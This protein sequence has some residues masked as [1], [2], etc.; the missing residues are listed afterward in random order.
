MA[1]KNQN[2]PES[3]NAKNKSVSP[4][5]TTTI[6]SNTVPPDSVSPRGGSITPPSRENHE[7]LSKEK[8]VARQ[9]FADN[10]N[11][12]SGDGGS[13]S[14][15]GGI[16]VGGGGSGGGNSG[17][18]VSSSPNRGLKRPRESRDS[19][20]LQCYLCNRVFQ[21]KQGLSGHMKSHK[22]RAW[23]GINPPPLFS[24]NEFMDLFVEINRTAEVAEGQRRE[25]EEAEVNRPRI[26]DLNEPLPSDEEE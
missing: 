13:G 20:L 18:P 25:N 22:D 19:D 8:S 26:P 3:P 14:G 17:I 24:R 4:G 6:S 11:P 10:L 15:I 16:P 23:R 12:D 2:I 21:C 9:L 1:Q 7:E 5:G